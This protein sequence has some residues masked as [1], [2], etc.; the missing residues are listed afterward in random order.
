[1]A[2]WALV[3]TIDIVMG[4]YNFFE[5]REVTNLWGNFMGVATGFEL[6]VA[7]M[8]LGAWFE[9]VVH[10]ENLNTF[11]MINKFVIG[12]QALIGLVNWYPY[13]DIAD[14]TYQN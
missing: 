10:L 11:Y 5:V 3:P 1:M 2:Y 6:A 4:L 14:G 7:V 8:G 9:S 12:F 13:R